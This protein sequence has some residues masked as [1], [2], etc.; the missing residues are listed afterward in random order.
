MET[1]I[2]L[3]ASPVI[4]Q[5]RL[6]APMDPVELTSPEEEIG[7]ERALLDTSRDLT[8]LLLDLGVRRDGART[9][10]PDSQSQGK[11]DHDLL[12]LLSRC[13]LAQTCK[14]PFRFLDK[15]TKFHVARVPDL[16]EALVRLD[17]SLVTSD[18]LVKARSPEQ[19][20]GQVDEIRNGILL[21]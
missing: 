17:C 7:V 13:S 2:Q 1:G 21:E 9:R 8:D 10:E 11:S 5:R 12:H 19:R 3:S 6:P 15:V 20:R 14:A 16:Q 18:L 4:A